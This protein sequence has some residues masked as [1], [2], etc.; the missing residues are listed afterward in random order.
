MRYGF[1]RVDTAVHLD[2]CL[3]DILT[4]YA[5]LT[6]KYADMFL[7]HSRVMVIDQLRSGLTEWI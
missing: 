2:V 6:S 5:R 7:S 4:Y 3:R 1:S